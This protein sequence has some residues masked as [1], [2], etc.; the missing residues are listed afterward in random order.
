MTIKTLLGAS[1]LVLGLS[2]GISSAATV[3]DQEQA[4]SESLTSGVIAGVSQAQTFTVG[5][6]GTLRQI[7]IFM[8]G[9]SDFSFDIRKTTSSGNPD[10]GNVLQTVSASIAFADRAYKSISLNTNVTIGDELA[11]VV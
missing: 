10:D 9:T 11:F 4:S 1:A 6:T 8:V 3:L 7:D 2:A 5:K